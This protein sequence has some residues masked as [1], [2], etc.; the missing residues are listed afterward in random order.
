MSPSD[1]HDQLDRLLRGCIP[2]HTW[3]IVPH[4][5]KHPEQN[6]ALLYH[7]INA[8]KFERKTAMGFEYFVTL[9]EDEMENAQQSHM[10]KQL[11][12]TD[13]VKLK[14]PPIPRMVG[15]EAELAHLH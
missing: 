8:S 7:H 3:L 9:S 11:L 6:I 1:S 15:L 4:I 12:R 10:M 2:N 13:V 5:A 14:R